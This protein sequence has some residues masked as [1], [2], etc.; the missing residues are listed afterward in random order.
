VVQGNIK[1][2][3]RNVQIL[4]LFQHQAGAHVF[5]YEIAN[6]VGMMSR[7]FKPGFKIGR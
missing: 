2:D 5:N 6:G 7:H 1:P 4:V 3:N